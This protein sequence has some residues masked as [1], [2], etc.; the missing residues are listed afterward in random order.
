MQK[1]TLDSL[2]RTSNIAG[3]ELAIVDLMSLQDDFESPEDME[4]Q[5]S[6]NY[7]ESVTDIDISDS[8]E[9]SGTYPSI[10]HNN[11]VVSNATPVDSRPVANLFAVLNGNRKPKVEQVKPQQD[12]TNNMLQNISNESI[13]AIERRLYNPDKKSVNM[14]D[15]LSGRPK[16]EAVATVAT[17]GNKREIAKDLETKIFQN[18]KKVSASSLLSQP[19]RLLVV[20]LKVDKEA[21]RFYKKFENPLKSRGSTQFVRKKTMPVTLR[22]PPSKLAPFDVTVVEDEPPKPKAKNANSIF[23]SMMKVAASD[24]VKLTPIQRLKSLDPPTL[25]L[26]DFHIYD[27]NDINAN[28]IQSSY[29]STLTRRQKSYIPID[30]SNYHSQINFESPHTYSYD[31]TTVQRLEAEKLFFS[32]CQRWG[33]LFSHLPPLMF[34]FGQKQV[35]WPQLFSPKTIRSL[36]ILDSNKTKLSTWINESFE[37]LDKESFKRQRTLKRKTKKWDGMS[38]FIVGDNESEN[39]DEGFVPLLIIQGDTGTGKSA[40]VYASM[41]EMDGYVHE[42]NAGQQRSRRDLLGTLKELCTTQLIHKQGEEK[43][44]QKGI[45]LLEDCDI[46]FEQDR[47]F[48]TVVTEVLEISRRPIVLTCSDPAVIPR[49][50]YNRAVE[51]QCIINLNQGRPSNTD[52][53]KDYIWACAFTQGYNISY[54]VFN[55]LLLD[56]DYSGFKKHLD[57]RHLL[58]S[59]Q[60]LCQ[61]KESPLAERNTIKLVNIKLNNITDSSSR[62]Q[63]IDDVANQM[64]LL[65]IVDQIEA[66]AISQINHEQVQNELIDIYFIDQTLQ[67]TQPLMPHEK[68]LMEPM[69]QALKNHGIESE[70]EHPKY[71]KNLA[72]LYIND[73][74]SSR[75]RPMPAIL[76][77]LNALPRSTRSNRSTDDYEFWK[78]EITGIPENSLC[79][80][81]PPT[82]FTLDFAPYVRNWCLFQ[83][84]LDKLDNDIQIQT[85]SHIKWREFQS[86]NLLPLRTSPCIKNN[87]S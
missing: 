58:V 14:K 60:M 44:F 77:G 68:S 53:Y 73:F 43:D 24:T 86:K 71:T 80:Y 63:N 29:L 67:L 50:L 85:K 78:P 3:S 9:V 10:F 35:L 52:L 49:Q 37:K 17:I 2:L 83:A 84:G 42:I 21:L 25:M 34:Q 75:S 69:Y 5:M 13:S 4:G 54:G 33:P 81:L 61:S 22:L 59:C 82:H 23:A 46:L 38:N 79:I 11:K 18:T 15:L 47:T 57:I 74:V 48:W 30:N 40:A 41:K 66:R 8:V 6:M 28:D 7:D 19:K 16:T 70:K 55:K 39:E 32:V 62:E 36:L 64:D 76:Q 20:T 51:D 12:I 1:S 27:I 87:I 56:K 72:R 26:Q 65:S 31:T 45:V